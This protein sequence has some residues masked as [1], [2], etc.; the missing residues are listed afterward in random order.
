VQDFIDAIPLAN[1]TSVAS[2]TDQINVYFSIGDITLNRNT[3][4][5]KT[6]TNVVLKFSPRDE[7]WSAHSYSNEFKFFAPFI[8]TVTA[9]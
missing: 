4:D 2:G 8:T 9:L 7:T 5:E 6:Y 1:W 3:N